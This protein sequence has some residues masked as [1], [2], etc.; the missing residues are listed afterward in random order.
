M[1]THINTQA[2]GKLILLGEYAVL[3]GAPALVTAVDRYARVTLQPV[4]GTDFMVDAPVVG[5]SAVPFHLRENGKLAFPDSIPS[6]TIGKLNFFSAALEVAARELQQSSLM[7]SPAKISLDTGDFFMNR[8]GAK[9]GLGSSAAITIS[10][11][12]AL[13]HHAGK[14]VTEEN[15]Y[16]GLFQPAL[17]AHRLAQGNIGSGIDVAASAFGGLLQYRIENRAAPQP[18]IKKIAFPKNLHFLIIWSGQ[19]ASTRELVGRVN[20]FKKKDSTSF[21]AILRG[22]AEVSS[23]GAGA[24][25]SQQL[26]QFFKMVQEYFRLMDTLGQRS[27][28]PII[29]PAHRQIA[30]IVY[31]GDAVY[32]PSGAGGGDLGIAFSDS[33][34]ILQA[35]AVQLRQAGFGIID[36]NIVSNGLRIKANGV[37]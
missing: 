23:E 31:A 24:L 15:R 34:Q 27:D 32:K 13:F 22:M 7:I 30:K 33:Q 20:E 12:G 6:G 21:T 8:G 28:A 25:A 29:S 5:A 16:L 4:G 36:L 1:Q 14:P 2:P 19:S 11:L 9:L 10:L 26:P 18:E 17:E 37:N 35:C 3:E